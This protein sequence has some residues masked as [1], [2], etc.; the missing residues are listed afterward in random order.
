MFV[1]HGSIMVLFATGSLLTVGQEITIVGCLLAALIAVSIW[2]RQRTNWRWQPA[3]TGDWIKAAFIAAAIAFFL[4]AS[5]GLYRASDP[6]LLPWYLGVLGIG[7]FGVLSV[8]QVV[9]ASQADF[10]LRC[11]NFDSF[12]REVESEPKPTAEIEPRWKRASRGIITIAFA[13]MWLITVSSFYASERALSAA[14]SSPTDVRDEAIADHGKVHYIT[15]GE[16]RWIDGLDLATWIG[17]PIVF[18]GGAILHFFLGVKL[19][20]GAPTLAERSAKRTAWGR[21]P[22][23]PK[24]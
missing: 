22:P 18:A 11:R 9:D 3:Y 20:P 6:R 1:Y 23:P 12:G 15:Q 4:F 7:V 8:L 17:M 21:V 10:L 24:P 16:K 5:G 13:V 2:N 14:S 19:F